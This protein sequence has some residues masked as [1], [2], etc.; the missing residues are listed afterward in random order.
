MHLRYWR[1]GKNLFGMSSVKGEQGNSFVAASSYVKKSR[2][3]FSGKGNQIILDKAEIFNSSIFLRGTGHRLI[4]EKGVKIYNTQIKIIGKDNLIHI[5]AKSSCGGGA[6]ICGGNGICI[7]IGE[8]CVLAEGVQIWST[9]THSVIQDGNLINEPKSITIGDHVWMGKD[10][11]VLKGVTVGDNSVIGMRSIVTHDIA[12]GTLN[13]G[14]PAKMIKD[15]IDWSL[16]NPNN[17]T[18]SSEDQ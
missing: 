14:C 17:Q 13:V 4:L 6:V 15:G 10:V 3:S 11:A 2:I 16:R 8:R 12:P 7:T 18:T 1:K 5:K 9:D